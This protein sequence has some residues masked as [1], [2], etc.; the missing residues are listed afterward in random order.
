LPS[1]SSSF[2]IQKNY[3]ILKFYDHSYGKSI[4]HQSSTLRQ[5]LKK[6][7]GTESAKITHSIKEITN[8]LKMAVTSLIS[9]H[10]RPT[11]KEFNS[12]LRPLPG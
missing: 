7:F 4:G 8:G 12:P 1:G 3:S 10:P 11:T 6:H 5:M 2:V 9:F